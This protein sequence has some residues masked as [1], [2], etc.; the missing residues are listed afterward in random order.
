MRGT[1]AAGSCPLPGRE[2]W[3]GN[4]TAV[5]AMTQSLVSSSADRQAAGFRD[6][7]LG[8]PADTT[9]GNLDEPPRGPA[10][11]D[12][13]FTD[14]VKSTRTQFY[15]SRQRDTLKLGSLAL[16]AV[17]ASTGILLAARRR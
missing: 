8:A 10:A 3:V 16:L 6:A 1:G 5:M 17:G 14:R 15:T 13:R 4:S 2:I 7:Q 9:R 11:I 12:G